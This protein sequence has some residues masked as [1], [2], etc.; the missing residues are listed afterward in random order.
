MKD[1]GALLDPMTFYTGVTSDVDGTLLPVMQVPYLLK[2]ILKQNDQPTEQIQTSASATPAP[3]DAEVIT[4]LLADDSPSVRKVQSKQLDQLGFRVLLAQDGQEAI[5]TL[6]THQV[7]LLVTDWEMPRI[8]GAELVQHTR[9]N[10]STQNLPIVVISSKVNEAFEKE[11]IELGATACLVKP[12]QP[13]HFIEK[14]KSS[15]ILT[16]LIPR[17]EANNTPKA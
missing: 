8:N 9:M 1:L 10:Q 13:D 16:K 11:A 14:L 6:N 2:W 4:V 17:L 7:D 5:D 15:S 12:F 3:I